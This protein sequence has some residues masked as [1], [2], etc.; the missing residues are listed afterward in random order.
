MALQRTDRRATISAP[1]RC[2]AD[3]CEGRARSR[4]ALRAVERLQLARPM[5]GAAA[6]HRLQHRLGRRI[7]R[8]HEHGRI[9]SACGT[10]SL[11]Q[12]QP[13]RRRAPCSKN[14]TPVTLPPGRAR[15]AT[16]P[17]ADRIADR[18][19]DDRN[20]RGRLPWPR[21]APA[22]RRASAIT[23]TLRAN[24][25]GRQRRQPIVLALRPAV[26]DRER[27]G[28]RR[29]RVRCSPARNAVDSARM[30]GSSATQAPRNPITGIA[31]CCARAASGHAAAAPPS[32]VMNSR[33]FIRS[34]RRRGRA[35]SAARRGR[36]PW[37]S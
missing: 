35:A 32:S 6:S 37:R 14:V 30:T 4:S 34:P 18:R 23:S 15:L 7:V 19:E 3:R 29:S 9:A 20:R 24:Q 27:S 12:L 1:T 22:C 16:R 13:L 10:S 8:I 17:D 2:C 5:R 26:F 33:R 36:A 21:D 28:P 25:I 11:Q 31:G